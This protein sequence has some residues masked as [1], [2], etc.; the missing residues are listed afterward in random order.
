MD[1]SLGDVKAIAVSQ[2][3]LFTIHKINST[4]T[5]STN[6]LTSLKP[7]RSS[8][9][10]KYPDT[11]LQAVHLGNGVLLCRSQDSKLVLLDTYTGYF[12][13]VNKG[14]THLPCDSSDCGQN[15][16][17]MNDLISYN[18]DNNIHG[19]GLVYL[20]GVD[21]SQ[22]PVTLH[23]NRKYKKWFVTSYLHLL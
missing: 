9:S 4:Q 16:I 11:I 8:R 17:V 14:T 15:P 18:S 22:K 7:T 5:F 1:K 12:S 19:Q 13:T 21:G 3:L 2:D 10:I 23:Y 6:D 20:Y